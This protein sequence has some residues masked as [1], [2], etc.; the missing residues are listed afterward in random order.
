[1]IGGATR[2]SEMRTNS[3]FGTKDAS[4]SP[5]CQSTVK[6]KSQNIKNFFFLVRAKI[7]QLSDGFC[8]RNF[9][10]IMS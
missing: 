8:V 9:V 5:L 7:A 3:V 4:K 1:M 10:E 2:V 6:K